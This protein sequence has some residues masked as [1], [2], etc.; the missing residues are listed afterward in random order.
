MPTAVFPGALLPTSGPKP[1]ADP[2]K[3]PHG[4][5]PFAIM[6][7]SALIASWLGWRGL[8]EP[9]EFSIAEK[10]ILTSSMSSEKPLS[11][12]LFIA[13]KYWSYLTE[14]NILDETVFFLKKWAKYDPKAW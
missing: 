1:I 3:T 11:K 10:L 9:G 7:M 5:S 12:D 4:I 14:V 2:I 8:M 6:A 13:R